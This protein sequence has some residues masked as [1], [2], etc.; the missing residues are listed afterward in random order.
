MRPGLKLTAVRENFGVRSFGLEILISL[1]RLKNAAAILLLLVFLFNVAGYRLFF[2]YADQQADQSFTSMVDKGRYQCSSLVT[3]TL[4]LHMPYISDQGFQRADGQIII[5][6]QIYKYV[7]RAV[8]NDSLILQC[9]PDASK[10]AIAEARV[11]YGISVSGNQIPGK[12]LPQTTVKFAPANDYDIHRL[13]AFNTA[14][15]AAGSS[16]FPSYTESIPGSPS[17]SLLQPPDRP[18][19]S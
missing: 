8:R 16:L 4:P 10:T 14:L 6:G 17:P 11:H 5:D 9:L 7:S 3:V 13:P 2:L 1:S 19:F 18:F 12:K 15:F